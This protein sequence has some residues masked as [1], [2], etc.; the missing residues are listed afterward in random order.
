MEIIHSE[1]DSQ[2]EDS[3]KSSQT[4]EDFLVAIKIHKESLCFLNRLQTPH[5]VVVS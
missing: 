1:S 3:E 2:I 5:P 4:R